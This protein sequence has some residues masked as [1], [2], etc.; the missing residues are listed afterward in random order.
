MLWRRIDVGLIDGAVNGV[1]EALGGA[2]A[3]LRNIQNGLVRSYAAWI[4]FG[5]VAVLMYVYT[6]VRG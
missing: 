6:L 3:L 4:L 1:G 5:A 2:A